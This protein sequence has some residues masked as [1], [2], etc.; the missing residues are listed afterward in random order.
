[1]ADKLLI[2][3]AAMA[4]ANKSYN[5][6]SSITKAVDKSLKGY[7]S[8]IQ[9]QQ[10]RIGNAS[11]LTQSYLDKLPENPEIELLDENLAKTITSE[12]N[13]IR[14]TIG[15]LN[16]DRFADPYK[17]APGT[18]EYIN[19][20]AELKKQEKLL[21]K[22]LT[23][24]KTLQTAKANWIKEHPNISETWKL[25]HAD[26]YI[27][28][29]QILNKENPNYETSRNKDGE[30]ILSTMV[31]GKKIDI[32]V[33]ELDDWEQYPLPEIN[34]INEFYELANTTG[35]KGVDIPNSTL[36]NM[37]I[38]LN[39]FIG[40]NENALFSLMFD[41]LPIGDPNNKMPF[42]TNEELVE[43]FDT[44]SS[45]DFDPSKDDWKSKY[46]FK[47]MREKVVNRIIERVQEENKR[48]KPEEVGYF[49]NP[50][51]SSTERKRKN[52]MA[53]NTTRL[54]DL[55]QKSKNM[56][57]NEI[58]QKIVKDS[59]LSAFIS[60][61]ASTGTVIMPDKT[62]V[63]DMTID[64]FDIKDLIVQ[65]KKDGNVTPLIEKL[66]K[67]LGAKKSDRNAVYTDLYH[68]D[69]LSEDHIL[70]Q[71]KISGELRPK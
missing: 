45:G 37:K 29:G 35:T 26:K 47:D 66:M 56:T 70:K 42:F 9:A 53:N 40:E 3:G 1:M 27:A 4:H 17:Y 61:E 46:D 60:E 2:L 55:L 59:Y 32:K 33:D 12:L 38:Y 67:K 13:D 15:K 64:S 41:D 34:K 23:E 11:I 5:I 22:R 57:V 68:Y 71:I 49:N 62:T 50:D 6:S 39:N 48:A 24:A 25:L 14:N 20:T 30:L 21:T 28:L 51:D 16:M 43:L 36:N 18:Q 54:I 65:F 31:E 69:K 10:K 44:D 52:E 7:V 58:A 8:M 63:T 19:I